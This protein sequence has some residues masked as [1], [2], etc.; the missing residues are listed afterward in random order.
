[1]SAGLGRAD[2]RA[3]LASY[4]DGGILRDR[5][6]ARAL[7]RS[8]LRRVVAVLPTSGVVSVV[9]AGEGLLP[10]ALLRASPALRV[11]AF[12][13]DPRRRRRAVA[14]LSARGVVVAPGAPE[15]VDLPR[16]DAVVLLRGLSRLSR[17]EQEA[18]VTRAA[19]ALAPGGVLVVRV[20]DGTGGLRARLRRA[21]RRVGR[22]LAARGSREGGVR[23]PRAWATAFEALGFVDVSAVRAGRLGLDGRVL[24]VGRVPAEG[25]AAAARPAP[26]PPPAPGV[27]RCAL[28]GS[29]RR[30]LA[31]RHPQGDLVRCRACGLAV[32]ARMPGP[33]EAL[34][35][36]DAGYF[37][38][39]RGYRDY[40]GE[41]ALYRAV[42]RRRLGR[43]RAFGARGRLLDVGAATGSFLEEATAA[44]FRAVGLE[45]S[46][47]A[48]AVARAAGL[49]VRTGSIE[50]AELGPEPFDVVTAFDVVE[51][52]V[53]PV[54]GLARLAT[55]ARRGGL[56][57]VSVPDF[58]GGWARATGARWPFVTPTEHLHYFTRRT[59][60][61]ALTAVGLR[62]L[63][64]AATPTPVSWGR[65]ARE[66]PS[67]LGPA[68]ESLLGPVADRGLALPFGTLL[69]IARRA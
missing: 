17:A 48:G 8:V 41:K 69:A 31:L 51:H 22:G 3:I 10:H 53:D 11:F 68:V 9:G 57:A 38:G 35:Q 29:P 28:C 52:L 20:L 16:S 26:P 61:A 18:A 62:V 7:R 27:P 37:R 21:L 33:A 19:G 1:M 42:F 12:E 66:L 46:A 39:A 2:R 32:V 14:S 43:L 64:V 45:P 40:A 23:T 36:Y 15:R 24:V 56:V 59:L 55:W 63:E 44:G 4:R 67:E 34:A 6:R 5:L 54:A 50:G 47:D 60:R 13:A 30:R 49:D 25:L 58:G 65:L